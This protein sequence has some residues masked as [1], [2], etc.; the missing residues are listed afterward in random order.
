MA[1]LLRPVAGGFLILALLAGAA[2]GS[3][4]GTGGSSGS[5]AATAPPAAAKPQPPVA[6]TVQFAS[7]VSDP[8]ALLVVPVG[9]SVEGDRPGRKFSL[10]A[11]PATAANPALIEIRPGAPGYP[12][13]L[14]LRLESLPSGAANELPRAT[15]LQGEAITD[16]AGLQASVNEGHLPW[17][18]FPEQVAAEY[19]NG[20]E[21]APGALIAQAIQLAPDQLRLILF[22]PAR[23]RTFEV[24]LQRASAAV[25]NPA[26]IVVRGALSE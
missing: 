17:R 3:S 14:W 6:L 1:R 19:L 24:V 16:R 26:W 21:L 7:D 18:I 23:D 4:S 12:A 10:R 9:W 15:V 25:L 22:E 20:Q 13:G 11:G 2:C 5:G 8:A